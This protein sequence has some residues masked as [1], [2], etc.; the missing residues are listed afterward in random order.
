MEERTADVIDLLNS[1]RFDRQLFD[2]VRGVINARLIDGC[3]YLEIHSSGCSLPPAWI[4]TVVCTVEDR[5][6][7][8]LTSAPISS[9]IRQD[10]GHVLAKTGTLKPPLTS[11]HMLSGEAVIRLTS[12][13]GC[14]A[15]RR[16]QPL[17]VA[18]PQP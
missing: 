17:L 8:T 3:L 6:T 12:I 5:L 16:L 10:D 9:V 1:R 11:A 14:Q 13:S 15:E 2:R 18:K 7:G 4:E